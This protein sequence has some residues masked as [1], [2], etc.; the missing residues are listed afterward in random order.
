M[1]FANGFRL[2]NASTRHSLASFTEFWYRSKCRFLYPPTSKRRITEAQSGGSDTSILSRSV[3]SHGECCVLSCRPRFRYHGNGEGGKWIYTFSPRTPSCAGLSSDQFIQPSDVMLSL[4]MVDL[5]Q[6]T[7]KTLEPLDAPLTE[8]SQISSGCKRRSAACVLC[9]ER[10]RPKPQRNAP[11]SIYVQRNGTIS[12]SLQE[13]MLSSL[14]S[15]RHVRRTVLEELIPLVC[16]C[17]SASSPD[18]YRTAAR[19][20]SHSCI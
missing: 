7:L 5:H 11:K 2:Y 4:I 19:V 20:R 6:S 18:Q 17:L 1:P 8:A 14:H 3:T 16:M 10:P 13:I 12:L 15:P 9:S